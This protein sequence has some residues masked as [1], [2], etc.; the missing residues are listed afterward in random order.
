MGQRSGR[1][2]RS[3][4]R[5]EARIP[6]ADRYPMH[7]VQPRRPRPHR[8]AEVRIETRCRWPHA[9]IIWAVVD[10]DE[11]FVRSWR[12][13]TARWYREATAN[14]DVAHPRR[15]AAPAG[16]GH[17]GHR[18]GLGRPDL[19][20][21]RAQVRGRPGDRRRW[22]AP[23]SCRP[24]IRGSDPR[25]RLAPTRNLRRSRRPAYDRHDHVFRR[26]QAPAARHRPGRDR[27][28]DGL[29]RPGRRAGGRD[30]RPVPRLQ[31]PQARAPAADRPAAADPDP[32]HQ[33][34]QPGAG[35]RL[36]GRRGDGAAHP[37]DRPL[38]RGRDGPAREQ[39]LHGHRRPPL[40]VRQLGEP[41]RGRL[42]PLLPRQGRRRSRRPD[43]LPGP[44]RA[45]AS[46][47]APS[48]RVA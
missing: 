36:P 24:H 16:H 18:P 17:P 26:V 6:T 15:R 13:A 35:A 25:T 47:P 27:R 45:R 5:A 10:G 4:D 43:L 46:T 19:G 39:P 42:Q 7:A 2:D 37:A 31:A 20:R 29:A 1:V 22:S 14:P 38:E 41:V 28:L 44:R 21:L 32:L 11:V 30:P 40:D 8:P 9:R 12:G 34:D 23:T 33:H 48:S 3:H